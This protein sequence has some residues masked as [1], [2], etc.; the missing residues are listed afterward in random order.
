MKMI[1][2]VKANLAKNQKIITDFI[3]LGTVKQ[4]SIK[5]EQLQNHLGCELS[6]GSSLTWSRPSLAK[7]KKFTSAPTSLPGQLPVLSLPQEYDQQSF[8]VH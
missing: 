7:N 3:L 4:A 8:T 6:L 1:S 5:P 2:L